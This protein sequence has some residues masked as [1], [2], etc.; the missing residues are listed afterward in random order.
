M[1]ELVFQCQH[2]NDYSQQVGCEFMVFASYN[3]HSKTFS[4]RPTSKLKHTNGCCPSVDQR[5]RAIQ[6]KTRGKARGII[7]ATDHTDEMLVQFTS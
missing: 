7:I 5:D 6:K 4:I 2:D 3:K 1:T